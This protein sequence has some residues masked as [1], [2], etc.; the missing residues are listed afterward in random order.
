M[1]FLTLVWSL[2]SRA[3]CK[4]RYKIIDILGQGISDRNAT[5]M[6]G[7]TRNMAKLL[8]NKTLGLRSSQFLP[9]SQ[10]KI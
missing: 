1:S 8:L 4:Y 6:S 5:I 3:Y 7:L 2:M 10:K 9:A